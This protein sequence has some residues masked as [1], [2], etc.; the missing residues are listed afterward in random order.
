MVK[1]GGSMYIWV[2][3][4][5]FIAILYS[6]NLPYR[7]D[8]RSVRVEPLAETVS[9]KFTMQHMNA[10]SFVESDR[11]FDKSI[12]GSGKKVFALDEDDI[13][14]FAP[15]GFVPDTD[16][17]S[18][19]VCLSPDDDTYATAE[20]CEE[21][22][23]VFL[24]T[25]GPI[26]YRWR[27]VKTGKP[28]NDLLRSMKKVGAGGYIFGYS[29]NA[30]EI[31]NSTDDID[32]EDFEMLSFRYSGSDCEIRRFNKERT[33]IPQYILTDDGE[34]GSKFNSICMDADGCN[35]PCLVLLDKIHL[36]G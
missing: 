18:E 25:Y 29:V 14:K 27:N 13:K 24:I 33:F 36:R 12:A 19:I 2:L 32:N 22:S 10:I 30:S 35:L 34:D 7:S 8:M 6:F 17:Y 5:T 1:N 20:A 15:Y 3:L 28:N 9:T 23:E 26:P 31:T 21:D 16:V 11:K 4:A